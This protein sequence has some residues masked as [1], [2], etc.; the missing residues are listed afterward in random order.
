MGSG[1][2][3]YQYQ[4]LRPGIDQYQYKY[5]SQICSIPIPKFRG[6]DIPAWGSAF[7]VT[8]RFPSSA[9]LNFIQLRFLNMSETKKMNR[10]G[11]NTLPCGSPSL[12]PKYRFLRLPISMLGCRLFKILAISLM[13]LPLTPG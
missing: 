12:A 11:D 7:T 6:T 3:Q 8:R 4:Y 13:N 10:I 9:N 2:D 1:I 5:Q